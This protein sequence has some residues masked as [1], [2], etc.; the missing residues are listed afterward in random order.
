MIH[1]DKQ[2]ISQCPIG[3]GF[4]LQR[5]INSDG[6]PI[7]LIM[8]GEYEVWSAPTIREAEMMH[9]WNYGGW[10]AFA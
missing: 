4:T 6:E 3:R 8:R 2:I 9:A 7:S 1:T 10:R 5:I